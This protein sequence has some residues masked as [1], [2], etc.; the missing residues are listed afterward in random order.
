VRER[1]AAPLLELAAPQRGTG[2]LELRMTQQAL[3]DAVGSVREVVSRT[4]ND[5]RSTGL[6]AISGSTITILDEEKLR[7]ESICKALR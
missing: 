6:I 3:A 4:L 2:L 7:R 1:T 5:L